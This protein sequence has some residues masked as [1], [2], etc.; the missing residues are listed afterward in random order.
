MVGLPNN[1]CPLEEYPVIFYTDMDYTIYIFTVTAGYNGEGPN[2][3]YKIL[4]LAGFDSIKKDAITG[5]H[6]IVDMIVLK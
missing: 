6:D 5:S 4:Q 3:L 1:K 2:D